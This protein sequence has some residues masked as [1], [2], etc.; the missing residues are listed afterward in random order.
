MFSE[1]NVS[2]NF[3]RWKKVEHWNWY[4]CSQKHVFL[5]FVENHA[6]IKWK[7]EVNNVKVLSMAKFWIWQDSQYLGVTQRSKYTRICLNKQDSEYALDPKYMTILS[8]AKLWICQ[9]SQKASVTQHSEYATICLDRVLNISWV[10]KCQRFEYGRVLNIQELHR[11]LNMQN[12][13]KYV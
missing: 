1:K 6:R 8:I 3:Q 10:L 13:V 11:I 5:S 12:L 9:A 2:F 4:Q 7:K